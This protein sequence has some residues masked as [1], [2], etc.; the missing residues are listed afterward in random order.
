M[1]SGSCLAAEGGVLEGNSRANGLVRQ[2]AYQVPSLAN[3]TSAVDPPLR[4]VS[5]SLRVTEVA[6]SAMSLHSMMTSKP[7]VARF[8]SAFT[9]SIIELNA[10]AVLPKYTLC[11][12]LEAA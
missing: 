3:G 5:A 8:P 2:C 6:I 12:I 9:Y 1:A 4:K 10:S 11:D 7:F